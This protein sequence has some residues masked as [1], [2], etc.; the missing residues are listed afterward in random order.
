[1][2]SK[3]L[4]FK[5]ANKN[6]KFLTMAR[7]SAKKSKEESNSI[8]DA[9]KYVSYAELTNQILPGKYSFYNKLLQDKLGDQYSKF[10]KC[11]KDNINDQEEYAN[12]I[13]FLL[14]NLGLLNSLDINDSDKN[15][16]DNEDNTQEDEMNNKDN[17]PNDEKESNNLLDYSITQV[18]VSNEEMT[19]HKTKE[20]EL[21]N[22]L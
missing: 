9:F 1:M 19:A 13:H 11:L 18:T 20:D 6:D 10:I 22:K 21:R 5:S 7:C 8:I 17:Q 14:N 12:Q 3:F 15:K 2:S 4:R 16:F